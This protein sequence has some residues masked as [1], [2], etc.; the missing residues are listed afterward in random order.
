MISKVLCRLKARRVSPK[1]IPRRIIKNILRI[2]P[3][4]KESSDNGRK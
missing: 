2:I 1:S 4:L 3:K